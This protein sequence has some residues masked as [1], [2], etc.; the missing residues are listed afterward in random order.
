MEEGAAA[1][2]GADGPL[3][4]VLDGF[5]PRRQQQEMAAAVEEALAEGGLLVAEAG[6]G[7][8]K[9]FAYLVPVL[10]SGKR[11]ILS[12]GTRHL[13]DQ[14]FHRDLPL[15][16]K[17]LGVPVSVALLKGRSNYLCLHRLDI[18]LAGGSTR[19]KRV[20]ALTRIHDWSGRTRSGD[21][22]E[23]GDV[24]EDSP[25]WP[26]VTSTAD[27]CLGAQ[28]PVYDDCY[29]LR[30]R[31]NAQEA[32]VVVVNHHLLLADM[33]LREEGVGEILPGAHAFIIDEAHQLPEVATSFFGESLSLHQ[34]LELVRD[35][36][37]EVLRE[38]GD[39]RPALQ[40]LLDGLEH[41]LRE[42]RLAFGEE[43]RRAAWSQLE[44]SAAVADAC[45]EVETALLALQL[46]LL[47]LAPRGRGLE[48]CERRAGELHGR[49]IRLTREPPADH[50]HWF[51]TSRSGLRI[52]L[53]P[54]EVA[55]RFREQRTRQPAAWIFVSATLAI[56][57]RFDHFAERLGLE[58]PHTGCWESPFDFPRQ[59]VFYVPPEMPQPNERGYAAAVLET[60][61][62]LLEASEGRAFLLFTSHRAL[63]AAAERLRG[64]LRWPLLVQGDAPR[65][66]LLA[67]F[68]ALGN[69]VLLGTGSFWEGV[70]VR[71]EAL[72]LVVIDKLPFASPDDP[73]LGAR[74]DAVKANGGN[75]F[76]DIQ[77]PAAVIALKQGVGRLI[78]DVTDRGVLVLC[79]PRLLDKPYGKLFLDSLPPMART[80]RLERVV[81]FLRA[82]RVAGD[83]LQEEIEVEVRP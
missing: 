77:L 65:G 3:A 67:R 38:A 37:G 66:E 45:G 13:Q 74:I 50:V 14:L 75:P 72:S 56:A 1:L 6:T 30:A 4:A 35:S 26:Q 22:A 21:I 33:A 57:G 31:R 16:R 46:G 53:T 76:R 29:L 55:A 5:A 11:V 39:A 9:T 71:G 63:Q 44:T 19:R 36:E 64:N 28:C 68:R 7:T 62:P 58:E 42:L 61:L 59:A 2:L 54:I 82:G 80:R 27:N 23:V 8:G 69:A 10:R 18:A 83:T 79:D 73:V 17:A 40:P 43:G 15:V 47:P 41:T 34:L 24:A 52:H 20:D 48:A 70:D 60:S 51:E 78:R 12:T 25:V 81:G 49:F 32:D